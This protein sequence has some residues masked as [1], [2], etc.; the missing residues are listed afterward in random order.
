MKD[1]DCTAYENYPSLRHFFNKLWVAEQ[2]GYDCGPAGTSP[3][4]SGTYVVALPVSGFKYGILWLSLA[5]PII[6]G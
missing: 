2:M 3:K 6:P 4:K 5:H 1:W